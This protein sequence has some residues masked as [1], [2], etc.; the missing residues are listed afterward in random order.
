ML[1]CFSKECGLCFLVGA[2]AGLVGLK[3]VKAPK[4]REVTVK[5]IAKGL[6]AK[7]AMDEQVSNFRE[8]VEDVYAQAKEQAQKASQPVVEEVEA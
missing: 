8:E 4:V 7:D 2:V 6:Q 3:V 5:T 1:K